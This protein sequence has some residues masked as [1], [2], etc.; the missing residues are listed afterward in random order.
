VA[1]RLDSGK[2]AAL[3]ELLD[4]LLAEKEHKV[5]IWGQYIEELNIIEETVKKT[6]VAYV[7][8]DGSNTAH[9][10][11]FEARFNGDPACRVYIGQVATGVSITLNSAQYMVYFSLPWNLE[12]YAQSLDRNHRIGQSKNV[13]VYRL[14]TKGVD[15]HIAS[16]LAVK[17]VV[18]DALVDKDADCRTVNR[19]I[20]KVKEL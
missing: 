14:L 5:I 17:Q 18:A 8:V 2:A 16:A 20:T 9:V 6:G 10:T 15:S 13:T 3:T 7:R 12:H 11:R 19:P 1:E 4:D